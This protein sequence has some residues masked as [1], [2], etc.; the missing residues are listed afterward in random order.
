MDTADDKVCKHFHMLE[1][2]Q[3]FVN[4]STLRNDM[5]SEQ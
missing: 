3:S 5:T 2:K 1:L 4:R